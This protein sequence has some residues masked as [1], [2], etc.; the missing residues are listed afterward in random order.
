MVKNLPADTGDAKDI[1]LISGLG[2]FPGGGHGNPLQCS[3]M[4]N[5]M[6]RG[7]WWVIVHRVAKSLTCL[8]GLSTHAYT[9]TH[10]HAYAY[11]WVI[12]HILVYFF[13]FIF[14]CWRLI[15]LNIVVVFAIH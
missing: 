3:C 11:T 5:A 12:T 15:T 8:K 13:S 4:E 1:G 2:R 14:I 7:A 9:Y 10:I 6:G